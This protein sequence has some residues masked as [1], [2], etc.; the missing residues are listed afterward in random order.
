MGGPAHAV[1]LGAGMA[2]VLAAHA[3]SRHFAAVT[4]IERDVLPVSP[5]HR[6]GV[7]QGRHAHLLWS[8]GAHLIEEMLPG[9]VE[10][11]L[12]LGA[13]R[14]GFQEDL[15]TLTTRGWQHRFP[16]TQFALLCTRPLLDWVVR[17]Q[18]LSAGRVTVRERAEVAGLAADGGRVTGAVVRD[19]DGGAESVLEA[20]LVVDATGRGS[21]LRHWLGDLGVPPVEEDVVDAGIA[22]ATRIFQAP[23][24]ASAGFPAVNIVSDAGVKL[25]GRFGVVYPVEGGRWIATLSCTRGADL[26]TRE[27]EFLPF[28]ETL[29]HPLIADLLGS[30]EPL[31]P[32]YG[33]RSGANRRLYPERLGEWPDGLLVV[34]DS[35]T[36]FN[37]VYGHGMSSAARSAAILDERLGADGY[38]PDAARRIQ[39]A[40]GSVV[41]DPWILA[42]FK[43]IDYVHSRSRTTDP[44]LVGSDTEHR[45][46]FSDFITS[47]TIRDPEVC[48]VVTDVMSLS[49]PQSEMGSARFLS[50]LHKGELRPELAGPPLR[51]EEM[52]L[53]DLDSSRIVG[54]T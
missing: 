29:A 49:A 20:D 39:R 37:P 5:A 51:S 53:V 24:G 17:D 13:R 23:P 21:R 14:L 47:R 32:V 15:V 2:G 18:I 45:L 44:R 48:A 7:P 40:V 22:Y 54:A 31:T 43:D 10:R 41:D 16:A 42:A 6:K 46:R 52:A 33:S 26:P 35:L 12:G 11:L 25:P 3:L 30:V 1:V 36:A 28:A 9:T 38:T 50:L 4:V 34:G 27:E 19:L 8:N